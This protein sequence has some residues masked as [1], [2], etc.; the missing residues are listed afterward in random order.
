MTAGRATV[1]W[2]AVLA[3]PT[4]WAVQL[5]AGYAIE[6]F[7]CSRDGGSGT[8][9]GLHTDTLEIVVTIAALAM[10]AVGAVAALRTWRSGEDVPPGHLAFLGLTALLACAVFAV[11]ILFAGAGVVALSPCEAG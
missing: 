3:A 6:D 7:G 5:V 10:V 1:L 9:A 2:I 11:T 8:V 4:A